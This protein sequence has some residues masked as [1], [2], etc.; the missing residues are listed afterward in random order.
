[1]DLMKRGYNEMNPHYFWAVRL[2][3][4]KKKMMEEQLEARR[5][6]FP[7]K[8]WVHPLDYHITLAF[9]G[10]VEKEKLPSVIEVVGE[11]IKGCK[12]FSLHIT[13]L[14]VF[15]NKLSPRIFWA[16]VTSEPQLFAL[17]QIVYRA[18]Q[19]V[20]FTLESRSY[21]PHIT[22]ARNWNGPEFDSKRLEE[23][24]PFK[25]IDTKFK[26]EEVVLYKTNLDKSPKYEPIATFSLPVE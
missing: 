20:G 6:L 25:E 2:P 22:L 15:G 9:L 1:M 5:N 18:C 24:N 10:S 21:S 8:R 19:Q 23:A 7:F 26:V 17:Q 3:D 4:E 14:G 11:G 12:S 16:A 13:G